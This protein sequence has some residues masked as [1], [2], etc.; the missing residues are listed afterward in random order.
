MGDIFAPAMPPGTSPSGGLVVS[1]YGVIHD[2]N[3]RYFHLQPYKG[4]FI[5]SNQGEAMGSLKKLKAGWKMSPVGMRE[6]SS[7][8][9]EA[10]R[11]A[12]ALAD[13]TP[14]LRELVKGFKR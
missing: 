13:A 14:N 5:V 2:A 7:R 6:E 8:Q 4:G 10:L 9:G 1:E 12:A 11:H 3:D